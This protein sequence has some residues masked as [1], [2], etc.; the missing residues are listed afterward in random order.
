MIRCCHKQPSSKSTR[1]WPPLSAESTRRRQPGDPVNVHGHRTS[2]FAKQMKRSSRSSAITRMPSSPARWNGSCGSVRTWPAR[3]RSATA[4][5]TAATPATRHVFRRRD[6]KRCSARPAPAT[7]AGCA[8]PRPPYGQPASSAMMRANWQPGLRLVEHARAPRFPP[9]RCSGCAGGSRRRRVS[10]SP[11]WKPGKPG[12]SPAHERKATGLRA[13]LAEPQLLRWLIGAQP[14][15]AAVRLR[16]L[17]QHDLQP[18][19]HQARR[20]EG[21]PDRAD[22]LDAGDL[23]RRPRCPAICSPPRPST[24]SA[25]GG[26]RRWA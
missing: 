17:R 19:D 12:S 22:R 7:G 25:G 8:R 13:M 15:L 1:N 26:C 16:V 10:C 21:Q 24:G 6:G 11:R 5:C 2:R 18:A 20:S 23:R 3:T 4:C 14:G 9:S